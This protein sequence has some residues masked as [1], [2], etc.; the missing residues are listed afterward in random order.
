[1]KSSK[2]RSV[3]SFTALVCAAGVA[4]ADNPHFVGKV[5][6]KL[7]ANNNVQVCFKEAGLG[8][9]QLIDYLAGANATATFVCVNH[10]GNCPNAAN[11]T[12]VNGPVGQ[13][14]QF[15][16]GKNGSIS[17]C[18][19]FSPPGAGGFSCPGGQTLTLSKVTYTD[20]AISDT[21]NGVSQAAV[22]STQSAN[23]FN[24]P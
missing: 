18:L 1:M 2:I 22:P 7:L 23:P 13:T 14:G 15:S 3:V 4:W 5:T 16:S 17:Q 8:S 11:K 20:I 21:T 19:T 9:N 10:G 24:C 6:S 12:T